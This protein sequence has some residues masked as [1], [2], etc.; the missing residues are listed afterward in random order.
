M[1]TLRRNVVPSEE[2]TARDDNFA[3]QNN[4]RWPGPNLHTS[5]MHISSLHIGGNVRMVILPWDGPWL[6]TD[7][8]PRMITHSSRW[9]IWCPL[10]L[11]LAQLIDQLH[12]FATSTHNSLDQKGEANFCCCLLKSAWRLV[13]SI[14]TCKDCCQCHT[15]T[16]ITSRVREC[17]TCRWNKYNGGR[18]WGPFTTHWFCLHQHCA[19]PSQH[20]VILQVW[21]IKWNRIGTE[22]AFFH[23]IVHYFHHTWPLSSNWY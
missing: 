2:T 19:S 21:K 1:C 5:K 9:T 3:L 20:G 12:A 6:I 22:C 7:I 8:Q 18:E 11:E 4:N 15:G 16:P 13:T 14:V 17:S 23:V 10:H